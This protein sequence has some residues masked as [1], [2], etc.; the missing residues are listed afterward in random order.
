MEFI[1]WAIQGFDKD[2]KGKPVNM[3]DP[4]YLG[5]FRVR[6]KDVQV[7]GGLERLK[8]LIEWPVIKMEEDGSE[9]PVNRDEVQDG[10]NL[11]V[12]GDTI[13]D[14]KKQAL[15]MFIT[16]LEEMY[17]EFKMEDVKGVINKDTGK[18]EELKLSEGSHLK[19]V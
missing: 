18:A 14:T 4:E 3:S 6:K 11:Y 19:V 8:D 16:V 17:T 2:E 10:V 9:T 5:V 12:K 15:E 7:E 13:E 1:S